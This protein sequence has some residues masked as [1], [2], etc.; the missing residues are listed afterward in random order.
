MDAKEL[1]CRGLNCPLPIVKI[2]K[3]F[4][5]LE[6]GEVLRV[7]ADDPAF[8]DDVNA[9]ADRMEHEILEATEGEI[10]VVV[11]KKVK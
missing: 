10:S 2:S 11:L 3:A 6:I 7:V 8:V 9:W 1:D 5:Q 4:R